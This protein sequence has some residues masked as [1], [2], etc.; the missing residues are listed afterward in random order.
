MRSASLD[1]RDLSSRHR[2]HAWTPTK[3]ELA[4]QVP[5][6]RGSVAPETNK[7]AGTRFQLCVKLSPYLTKPYAYQ[8]YVTNRKVAGSRPDEVKDFYQFT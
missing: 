6:D 7:M 5:D 2:L 3:P 4:G 8:R 1:N